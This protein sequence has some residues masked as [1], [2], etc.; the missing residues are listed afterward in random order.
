MMVVA[1]CAHLPLAAEGW[2]PLLGTT[3]HKDSQAKPLN[4]PSEDASMQRG[5]GSEV[6]QH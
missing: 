1:S 3:E 4:P 6:W 5:A 2:G